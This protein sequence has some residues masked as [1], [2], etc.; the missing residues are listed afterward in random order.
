MKTPIHRAHQP[1]GLALGLQVLPVSFLVADLGSHVYVG[2]AGAHPASFSGIELR[3][4]LT[5][6]NTG[7]IVFA[8]AIGA[9][10][11]TGPAGGGGESHDGGLLCLGEQAQR[12]F[13]A[14]IQR[15]P[16]SNAVEVGRLRR[17]RLP[18]LPTVA[19]FNGEKELVIALGEAE[20][21]LG[22]ET[23][24]GFR[25]HRWNGGADK[26]QEPRGEIARAC[27]WC[28][29][30]SHESPQQRKIR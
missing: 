22:M 14:V 19:K 17:E 2:S 20:T 24:P 23:F 7:G 30:A 21:G 15:H 5:R 18:V 25:R 6:S 8:G 27:A 28:S 3:E 1:L 13:K 12:V 10:K 9:V 16:G 4:E 26:E 11:P 29:I